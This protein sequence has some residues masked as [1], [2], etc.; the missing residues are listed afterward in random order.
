MSKAITVTIHS[1]VKQ[2]IISGMEE[3][4]KTP[5]KVVTQIAIVHT[6]ETG[7]RIETVY[8][9]SLMEVIDKGV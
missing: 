8:E 2:L 1:N 7:E 6:T 4:A 5:D 3:V 9:G